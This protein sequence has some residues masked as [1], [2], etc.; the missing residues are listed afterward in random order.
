MPQ[1]SQVRTLVGSWALPA[2]AMLVAAVAPFERALPGSAF[3][4]TL[5]TVE[6]TIVIAL[7]IGAIAWV[8]E[9]TAFVWRTPISL[10]LAAIVAIAIVSAAAAP[11]FKGNAA[12]VAA[13]LGTAALLFILIANV[14]RSS[15]ATKQIAAALLAS[16]SIVGLVAVLELAQIP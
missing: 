8:R 10:P 6:L 12:R 7:A 13:R 3:G 4:F 15:R 1:V 11:E 9:P 14:T 5:T 2:S 16:A